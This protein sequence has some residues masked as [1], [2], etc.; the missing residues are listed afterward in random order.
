MLREKDVEELRG[1]YKA[2]FGKDISY[3]EAEGLGQG[4][5]DIIRLVYE[6]PS[7]SSTK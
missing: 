2:R 3:E 4:L 1:L 6:N 7:V 5:I